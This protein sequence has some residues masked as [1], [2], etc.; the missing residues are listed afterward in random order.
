MTDQFDSP[1]TAG[2]GIE[3]KSLLGRLLLIKAYS[4]E[5]VMTTFGENDCIRADVTV[6]DGDDGESYLD[7]LIFPRILQS[8]VKHSIGTEKLTL[9]R[10]GQGV[11]KPGQS[12]PWRL[13]DPT[14]QDK[15]IARAHLASK[16]SVPF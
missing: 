11:A 16:Q 4:A 9:G 7:T 1:G 13:E 5:K 2:A 12:A 8:Q 3:W 6:L 15:T 14:E 10:L